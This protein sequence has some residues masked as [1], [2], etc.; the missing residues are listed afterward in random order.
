[1]LSDTFVS[2]NPN[3][4]SDQKNEGEKKSKDIGVFEIDALIRETYN[5]IAKWHNDGASGP[6]LKYLSIEL[7]EDIAGAA[8]KH[9][10]I[11]YKEA[12]IYMDEE[13]K[14]RVESEK[15]KIIEEKS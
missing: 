11:P 3:K 10:D 9:L 1:M 13:T 8:F 2:I 4:M 7:I 6:G 15:Q 14:K 5:K 12:K